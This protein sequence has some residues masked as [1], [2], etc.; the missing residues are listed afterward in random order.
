MAE[1][2]ISV[3]FELIVYCMKFEVNICNITLNKTTSS[4]EKGYILIWPKFK[5]GEKKIKIWFI[6]LS[7]QKCSNITTGPSL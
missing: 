7:I 4:E 6:P 3:T 5:W 1:L 2:L